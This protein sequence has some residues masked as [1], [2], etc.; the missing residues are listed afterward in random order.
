M[1]ITK[2]Y[3][4]FLYYRELYFPVGCL[5][6]AF[7]CVVLAFLL[8]RSSTSVKDQQKSAERLSQEL[9][10]SNLQL[11]QLKNEDQY[12]KNQA[13]QTDLKH[14][15]DSFLLS[16][17]IYSQ[18]L[19]LKAQKTDTSKM[20]ILYASVLK[21]LSEQNYASA[22]S[23]LKNLS[24][25]IMAANTPASVASANPNAPQSNTPPGAGFSQQ[26]VQTDAGTFTVDIIAADLNSTRVIV[27]TASDSDCNNNCPAMPLA[28]YVSRNGAFAGI[29]GTFFCPP[30]YPQCAGKTNSFDTLL[31]NKNKHYFN[32]D[33][34]VYST[35]PLVYTQ[36][37]SFGIR[38]Q[39]LDW[40]RD[41]G[42]DMVLAMQPLL[43]SGG[44]IVYGGSNDPKFGSRG[45]R[46][47]IGNKG[48]TVYIGDVLGATMS[49]SAKVLKTLGLE[50]A[51]NLDEGGSTALW[52]GG[53]KLGPGR[54]LPNAVLFV[55]K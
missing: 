51:L 31:M 9:S 40:G 35:V 43:I 6:L 5:V 16:N 4:R 44:N 34:N 10:L 14:I 53:Y 15:H 27:D 48:S 1:K 38:S 3:L 45:A 25:I 52:S 17:N 50:N 11:Q 32:S 37:S 54:N 46:G 33:N 23:T 12:K 47:F 36:G 30:E 39:S 19:D 8:Y 22:D 7:I 28:D 24:I 26:Q 13:L 21:N 18:I 41:T 29:N 2:K 20:D 42:V 49:E 55:R